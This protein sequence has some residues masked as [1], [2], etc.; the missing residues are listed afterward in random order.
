MTFNHLWIN[1]KFSL[2]KVDGFTH[3]VPQVL[4]LNYQGLQTVLHKPTA[5]TTVSTKIIYIFTH[6]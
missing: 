4:V 2:M 3:P 5:P 6:R 1:F